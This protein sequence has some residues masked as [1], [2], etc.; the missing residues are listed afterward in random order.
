[1]MVVSPSPNSTMITGT[2]ADSGAEMNMLTQGSRIRSARTERPIATPIGIPT[3]IAMALPIRN[4]LAVI[5][6]ASRNV[7]VGTISMILAQIAESGGM[8]KLAPLRPAISHRTAQMTSEAKSG[9]LMLPMVMTRAL[10]LP[11]SI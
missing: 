1:M 6:S 3:A 4:V 8:T 9:T 10:P 5:A 7:W 11:Y 2:S